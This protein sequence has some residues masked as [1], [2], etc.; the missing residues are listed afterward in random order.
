MQQDVDRWFKQASEDLK[1]ARYNFEGKKYKVS[2][3][4]KQLKDFKNKNKIEKMYLFGSMA[5]GK[6]RK[7][8]D[9]DLIVVS[10]KFKGKGLLE[11][12]PELYLKWE[13]G[14][15]VDFICYTPEEFNRLKRGVT[16]AREAVKN[17]I[18]I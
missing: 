1:A 15:P 7:Y 17:G 8:S 18:E 5:S 13:L 6:A 2:R 11:R 14:Y 9:V 3:L 4:I 12:S 10:K 16:I